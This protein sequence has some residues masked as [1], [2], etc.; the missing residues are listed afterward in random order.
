[1]WITPAGGH[2]RNVLFLA[3]SPARAGRAS[4]EACDC[5]QMSE[6]RPAGRPALAFRSGFHSCGVWDEGTLLR[7]FVGSRP[8]VQ[9]ERL[10]AWGTPLLLSPAADIRAP[11]PRCPRTRRVGHCR[12]HALFYALFSLRS[13]SPSTVGLFFPRFPWGTPRVSG[14]PSRVWARTA[15]G[16]PQVGSWGFQKGTAQ[17]LKGTRVS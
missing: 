2:R 6:Q 8:R 1:M 3:Q 17:F 13:L 4:E 15:A 5:L 14:N 10:A 9:C 12:R 16:C 7:G 11:A